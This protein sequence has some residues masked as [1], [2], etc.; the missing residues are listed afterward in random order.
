MIRYL[1]THILL[2]GRPLCRCRL[3]DAPETDREPASICPLCA[4]ALAV[5]L[6]AREAA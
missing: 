2:D 3:P 4:V 5:R 6:R 1:L